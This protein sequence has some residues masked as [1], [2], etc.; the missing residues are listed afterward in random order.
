MKKK[1]IAMI[2][3]IAVLGT[4]VLMAG[5]NQVSSNNSNT[6][7]PTS[8]DNKATQPEIMDPVVDAMMPVSL[9]G[10]GGYVLTTNGSVFTLMVDSDYKYS[11]YDLTLE[12][13]YQLRTYEM[14]KYTLKQID[15][16]NHQKA[17]ADEQIN[18]Y[19]INDMKQYERAT[20]KLRYIRRHLENVGLSDEITESD[21]FKKPTGPVLTKK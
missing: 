3:I 7:A 18:P 12:E 1:I 15:E 17:L 5:C 21:Y 6:T 8:E 11:Y 4:V 19:G 9:K 14:I 20:D 2:M 16:A 10:K 13:L